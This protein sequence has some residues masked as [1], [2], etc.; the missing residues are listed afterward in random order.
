MTPPPGLDL[1]A[2]EAAARAA[3]ERAAAPGYL[4]ALVGTIGADPFRGKRQRRRPRLSE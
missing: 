3:R 4:N 2:R 1:D